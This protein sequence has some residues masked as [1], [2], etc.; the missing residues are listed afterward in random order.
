MVDN[1]NPTVEP[2]L[3]EQTSAGTPETQDTPNQPQQSTEPAAGDVPPTE[4]TQPVDP[5]LPEDLPPDVE[6]ATADQILSPQAPLSEV[7]TSL[8]DYP[9][10]GKKKQEQDKDNTAGRYR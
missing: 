4:P 6:L 8:K 5:D 1:E 7:L 9:A 10:D 2:V 3:N